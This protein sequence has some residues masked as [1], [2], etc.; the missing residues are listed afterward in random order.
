[1]QA[2]LLPDS[3]MSRYNKTTPQEKLYIHFDNTVYQPGQTVWYK[4]YLQSTKAAIDISRNVY[5]DWFDEKGAIITR[6][7][8]PVFRA[9]GTGS[10]EIPAKYQG[11]HLY[12]RA[13]T[14]WMLNF[15]S[16]LLF[17]KELAV[18]QVPNSNNN[19]LGA[20]VDPS[21]KFFAE[22]GDMV[23]GLSSVLA[24]KAL[25]GDGSPLEIKGV[26]ID[27]NGKT[28]KNF[29]TEHDGMGKLLFTPSPGE[30]YMAQWS[31][32]SDKTYLTP[33]PT[34]KP[35]GIVLTLNEGKLDRTF[36]IN[37]TPDVTEKKRKVVVVAH[38]NQH[39][40]FR[41]VAALTDKKSITGNIPLGS[42]PSGVITLTILDEMEKPLA[43]RIF[44][45][46][47]E[48]YQLDASLHFDTIGL[49]KR[50]KN[51]YEIDIP[52][53][54]PV[55]L[56]LSVTAGDMAFDSTDNIIT[57]L[58]LSS[59]LKGHVNNPAYYFSTTHDSVK[60]HLDLVMLTNG[61]R[62]FKW[63][64]AVHNQDP[65]MKFVK[66]DQFL[67]F[68]ATVKQN[69]GGTNQLKK[70][71]TVNLILQSKD[72]SRSFIVVPF[73]DNS[74]FEYQNMALFDTVQ[75]FYQL[76]NR[77]L[78]GETTVSP[79]TSLLPFNTKTNLP[80]K[81][82]DFYANINKAKF[83]SIPTQYGNFF[84]QGTTLQ[85]VTVY[86]QTKSKS[87]AKIDE[88]N[89]EY[90]TGMFKHG[91]GYQFDMTGNDYIKS[92]TNIITY[93]QSKVP[94]LRVENI[95]GRTIIRWRGNNSFGGATQGD[96]VAILINEMV[97]NVDDLLTTP[98]TD[99]AYI[100]V[101]RP[102]FL[103]MPL[104]NGGTGAIAI[105][106][107]HGQENNPGVGMDKFSV[108]GYTPIK[109]FYSPDYAEQN[110]SYTQ[111][112]L[113]STLYWNPFILTDG[114]NNKQKISF[115]NNDVSHSLRVV[116]EGLSEDGRIIHI[117]KLLQ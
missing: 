27:K 54:I 81:K 57:S 13:Y 17:V 108:P 91:D 106:T 20:S 18:V 99:I 79:V 11:R 115:Y 96:P 15:D 117:S 104:G 109:E 29:T 14:Q 77:N 24:F 63:E 35:K 86:T 70:V 98:A 12:A 32:I 75:V 72:S 112:D 39:V 51:V 1:M 85:E 76:D 66:E 69:N 22:G 65:N 74:W 4:I 7:I 84:G 6:H 111:A 60:Q 80:I 90:T 37:F 107:N 46:D 26:I 23:E 58:L 40:L 50:E 10:F 59:E 36:H 56:S 103:G 95:G 82:P 41:A 43:E 34:A 113:R 19:R 100:K 16:S 116:I 48:E 38:A 67:S 61:W 53:S 101:F 52:D 47:N 45:V 30:K 25:Q 33:L 102:P 3:V 87:K 49:N 93:L 97:R 2:Q 88:L 92:S 110:K 64:E 94:G 105:Y 89:D 62:R 42:F 71:K 8:S 21:L 73:N 78:K 55:N 68:T 114:Y 31:G 5:I 9:T 83:E 44:F 28:I